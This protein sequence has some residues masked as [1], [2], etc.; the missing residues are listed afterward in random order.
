[1]SL[2]TNDCS[3]ERRL[4]PFLKSNR[5]SSHPPAILVVGRNRYPPND[6]TPFS[7]WRV[8]FERSNVLHELNSIWGVL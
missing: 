6:W 7:K 4:T 1:M 8:T 3:G 5:L 2:R